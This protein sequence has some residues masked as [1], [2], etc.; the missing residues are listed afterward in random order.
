MTGEEEGYAGEIED[1]EEEKKGEDEEEGGGGG[2]KR[3]CEV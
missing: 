3:G 2:C 1:E